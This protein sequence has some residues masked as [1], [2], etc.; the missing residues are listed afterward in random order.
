MR[1]SELEGDLLDYWVA[2]A[3]R[4]HLV[5]AGD[6]AWPPLAQFARL[7]PEWMPSRRWECGGPIIECYRIAVAPVQ[8]AQHPC[9]EARVAIV[10]RIATASGGSPL[11]AA[12]RAFVASRFGAQVPDDLQSTAPT[13]ASTA[14]AAS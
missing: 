13:I 14:G 12:M 8:G 1:V 5:T 7:R 11:V 10:D 2:R 9:W 6:G 3:D 4:Q